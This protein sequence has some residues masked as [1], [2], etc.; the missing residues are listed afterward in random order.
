MKI[1]GPFGIYMQTGMN[2]HAIA[3]FKIYILR[4]N[5]KHVKYRETITS[6]ALG[7]VTSKYCRGESY[8]ILYTKLCWNIIHC[9][10]KGI[11]Y[12]CRSVLR[13]A[14]FLSCKSVYAL[15]WNKYTK[16]YAVLKL[17]ETITSLALMLLHILHGK[18]YHISLQVCIAHC[19]ILSCKSV[20][21]II[22]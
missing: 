14:Q 1:P 3:Q 10:E 13:T 6:L 21:A 9:M 22:D 7:L 5:L 18:R 16:S 2:I 11:T 15:K 8:V 20:C 17:H 12:H 4:I 19:A